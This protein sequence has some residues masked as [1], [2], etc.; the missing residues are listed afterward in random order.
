VNESEISPKTKKIK[1]SLKSTKNYNCT[2]NALEAFLKRRMLE[3]NTD[4]VTV[5]KNDPFMRYKAPKQVMKNF[6]TF[7]SIFIDSFLGGRW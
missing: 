3:Y 2:L 1:N 4:E 7:R 6:L 5:I